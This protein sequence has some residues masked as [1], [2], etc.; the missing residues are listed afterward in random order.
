VKTLRGRWEK[1]GI[2][3]M[4]NLWRFGGL[5]FFFFFCLRIF[6]IR[7][8]Y[9]YWD[10]SYGTRR[11]GDSYFLVGLGL[12]YSSGCFLLCLF[13]FF[14][15]IVP[16]YTPLV[17]SVKPRTHFIFV[18]SIIQVKYPGTFQ[19]VT[20]GPE[21]NGSIGFATAASR[22]SR[23]PSERGGRMDKKAR[24]SS[25]LLPTFS[26]TR[27]REREKT[28]SLSVCRDVWFQSVPRQKSRR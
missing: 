23:T 1:H 28:P 6:S 5:F 7:S 22:G 13:A 4:G 2:Y 27:L 16:Y 10:Y 9:S 21:G 20:I 24:G 8:F 11:E 25:P 14:Y 26:P 17:V 18:L 15:S 19:V 3:C 12:V